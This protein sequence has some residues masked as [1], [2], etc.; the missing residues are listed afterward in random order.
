[1]KTRLVFGVLLFAAVLP[2][3]G[4][5]PSPG[6]PD[7]LARLR[8]AMER[9]AS[10]NPDLAAM[11]SRIDASRHRVPQ[12]AILPDPEIEFGIKDIPPSNPSFSRDD[13]TMEMVAARQ[14]FPGFGKLSTEGRAAQAELEG[15]EAEHAR[16]SVEVAADV[17]DSFFHLADLDSR[18]AILEETRRTLSD[19]VAATRERY[20]VGKGAQADVLRADLEKTAL[21]DRLAAL[22]A[23]RRSEAARFN[24]LQNLPAGAPVAP[25]EVPPGSEPRIV[26]RPV[27]PAGDLLREAERESPAVIASEARVRQAG[28]GVELAKL[29]RRP[30]WMLSGYYGRRANFED[31]AGLS[32]SFNLPWVHPKRL[33]ERRA[34]REAELAAARAD[35]AAVRNTLR[36]DIEQAYT[37]LEKNREQ[38]RLYRDSILPQAE[39]NYRA[40]REAYS[41]GS[42]DFLTF[43]RGVTDLATY[44][45]E[46]A[47]RESGVSRAIG[48]LQKASGI[49]LI[50]GTPAGVM[51]HEKS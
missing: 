49:A 15:A 9:A 12:A 13:F 28:E 6:S 32:V 42:I 7:W 30:D 45:M 40:S 17:A 47:E 38:V 36:R 18:V 43:V 33:S 31:L 11:E 5:S 27:P 50:A 1:M 14:R 19:A 22:K 46:S 41:A 23:G 48:M 44:Q 39:I 29:E 37:E 35:L 8:D 10:Q 26:A 20:R 3:P 25:V 51:I 2:A 34:E 4:E 16:H 24:A 21:E